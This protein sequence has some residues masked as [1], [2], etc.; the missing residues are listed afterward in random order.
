MSV[1]RLFTRKRFDV[2]A[3]LT[4][5][6]RMDA[7]LVAAGFPETSPWWRTEIEAFLRSGRRRWV[8]RAGRRA[9]KSSTLCRL[10]VAWSLWGTWSVPA[11]DVGVI[12]FVSVDR[13]E[14]RA[15]LRTIS[16]I[17]DALRVGYAEKG[18]ELE[19]KNRQ[20]LFRVATC[21]VKGTVGFTS[22]ATF[23]DEMARWES[24]ESAA[25]PAAEVAASLR[26][27]MATIPTAFE[28]CSSSPWGVD[29]FH[30]ELFDQGET[31]A[32]LTS[33]AA[34]WTANPTISEAETRELEPDPRIW[35]REYAAIPGATLTKA[36]DPA[37][38]EAAFRLTPTG[39]RAGGF[40]AIDASS[41]RGDSFTYI[42]GYATSAML[43]VGEVDGWEDEAMRATTLD[44]IAKALA[45]RANAWGAA[46]IFGDQREEAGLRS[47]L[48]ERFVSYSW[49]EASKEEAVLR[50]ARLLRERRLALTEH[51]RLRRELLELRAQLMP[52]GRT[53]Y[54]T[55]GRDY[56]S[57]LITLMHAHVDNRVRIREP[58]RTIEHKAPTL[59]ESPV[60]SGDWGGSIATTP[61]TSHPLD[62]YGRG[63]P[64]P[65]PQTAQLA[66]FVGGYMQSAST[67]AKGRE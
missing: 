64:A 2:D 62:A 9:G 19:L 7:A 21:S 59:Y 22:I 29:D 51:A 58:E 47:H 13:D 18:D 11:G 49:T 35:S 5:Y 56:A 27:T 25:N 10:A 46:A 41:L 20:V 36:F 60:A 43:V 39:E 37:D 33:F 42:G 48:R 38:V 26:P 54:M 44:K 34:T 31:D 65:M 67:A 45:G 63:R 61:A 16:A 55:N 57:A 52:S 40:V 3:F 30:A 32:Q 6:D 53:R 4:A 66:Q 1:S 24:R 8:I 14:A 12:P 15:R 28:V 50:L 23:A 17:L